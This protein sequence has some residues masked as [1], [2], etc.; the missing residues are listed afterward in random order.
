MTVSTIL[1]TLTGA[2][3]PP[4]PTPLRFRPYASSCQAYTGNSGIARREESYGFDY[5]KKNCIGLTI[6]IIF[7]TTTF[8]FLKS[9]RETTTTFN[10]KCFVQ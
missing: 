4:P 9:E 5:D 2:P 3:P 8:K 6:Y 1:Y 10:V 7:H